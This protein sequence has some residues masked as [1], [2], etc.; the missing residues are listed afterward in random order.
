VLRLSVGWY[1]RTM[2]V[3]PTIIIATLSEYKGQD[4]QV[5]GFDL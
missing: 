3:L 2:P 1:N 5:S 4:K